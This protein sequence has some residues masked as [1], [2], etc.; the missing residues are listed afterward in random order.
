VI[1]VVVG[2]DFSQ[3]LERAADYKSELGTL[4]TPLAHCWERLTKAATEGQLIS[5]HW[6]LRD[7]V[8][9]SLR[10]LAATGVSALIQE[11]GADRHQLDRVISVYLSPLF[12][13]DFSLRSWMNAVCALMDSRRHRKCPAVARLQEVA[14]SKAWK[15][16]KSENYPDFRNDTIGHGAYSSEDDYRRLRTLVPLV[17]DVTHASCTALWCK[18]AI[19]SAESVRWQGLAP[20]GSASPRVAGWVQVFLESEDECFELDPLVRGLRD[21]AAAPNLLLLGRVKSGGRSPKEIKAFFLNY[22]DGS[23]RSY[24]DFCQVIERY[25]EFI[26]FGRKG[27]GSPPGPDL[28]AARFDREHQPVPYL[29]AVVSAWADRVMTNE[30]GGGYLR[31]IGPGGVGKSWFA[32]M[33]RVRVLLEAQGV[34]RSSVLGQSICYRLWYSVPEHKESRELWRALTTEA[35]SA[36]L[37]THTLPGQGA[38]ASESLGSWAST[39]MKAS[40]EL[41]RG[42][43]LFIVLD[44]LDDLPEEADKE[45]RLTAWLGPL[46]ARCGVMLVS[47]PR[48]GRSLEDDLI[49][50][51]VSSSAPVEHI[52]IDPESA[53][54]LEVVRAYLHGCLSEL[55]QTVADESIDEIIERSDG[56]FLY[57]SHYALAARRGV[58]KPG[59]SLP[60]SDKLYAQMF[61]DLATRVDEYHFSCYMRLITALLVARDPLSEAELSEYWGVPADPLPAML[62]DFAYLIHSER[63]EGG[64]RQY[65]IGHELVREHL[66]QIGKVA[67]EMK[68]AHT[69]YVKATQWVVYGRDPLKA[70]WGRE[71]P[72]DRYALLYLPDHLAESGDRKRA[73]AIRRDRRRLNELL[74]G[75][76]DFR[77]RARFPE[78]IEFWKA[79]DEAMK[80]VYRSPAGRDQ[81]FVTEYTHALLDYCDTLVSISDHSGA[82][83]MAR[84]LRRLA[85]KRKD[86]ILEGQALMELGSTYYLASRYEE[87]DEMYRQALALLREGSNAQLVYECTLRLAETVYYRDDSKESLK[88][89]DDLARQS[90]TDPSK[91]K[92]PRIDLLRGRVLIELERFEDAEAAFDRA[93]LALKGLPKSEEA[94][95]LMADLFSFSVEV[96]IKLN[97]IKEALRSAKRA[98]DAYERFGDEI[99]CSEAAGDIAAINAREGRADDA[100][101]WYLMAIG[102]AK[103]ALSE[104]VLPDQYIW[105]ASFL[106]FQSRTTEA[107]DYLSKARSIAVRL[108][109]QRRLSEIDG[110]LREARKA[111]SGPWEGRHEYWF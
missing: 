9:C 88:M 3:A 103:S 50:L 24:P 51:E 64:E 27:P 34:D 109:Q 96:Y 78:A 47:R 76:R 101:R 53:E 73:G 40:P 45:K 28:I 107:E 79:A 55:G 84:R 33:T 74:E 59:A 90:A 44:G 8:E 100:E 110:L 75:A 80:A 11:A 14:E 19:V 104:D 83:R 82:A 60:N 69:E 23:R 1:N 62:G 56:L 39:L 22:L 105:Y 35:K 37:S 49:E 77:R 68:A 66:G 102:H 58:F 111:S 17:L 67:S 46:P 38:G 91:A 95:E 54:S 5:V 108:K 20:S 106:I 57:A 87:A 71:T 99:G 94:R 13:N 43:Y 63:R 25:F 89:C 31:L 98:Y 16:F 48:L 72:A 65:R 2:H 32:R 85:V 29:A 10:L 6:F 86:G 41:N 36:G 93:R 18:A 15:K 4:P 12:R 52:V 61:D 30:E 42:G 81:G 70:R 7:L 21:D 92:M 97:N 26:N